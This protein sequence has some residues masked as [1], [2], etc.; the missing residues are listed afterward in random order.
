MPEKI[1]V[2]RLQ[3]FAGGVGVLSVPSVS[4]TFEI[5]ASWLAF[6]NPSTM[7]WSAIET[8]CQSYADLPPSLSSLPEHLMPT[9]LASSGTR[10]AQWLGALIVLFQRMVGDPLPSGQVVRI[11]DAGIEL[12]L[13][14]SRKQVFREALQLAAQYLFSWQPNRT[15][16]QTKIQ[17]LHQQ[18]LDFVQRFKPHGSVPAITRFVYA[19]QLLGLPYS[20]EEG[21]LTVGWG[22]YRQRLWGSLSDQD[23]PVG[24]NLAHNKLQTQRYLMRSGLPVPLSSPVKD[25]AQADQ[26][27]ETL[28][29]P[30]VLKP[31]NCEQGT[32]VVVGLNTPEQLH[33][34]LQSGIKA[35]YSMM[36]ERFVAGEDYRFLVVKG[37]VLRVAQR[38]PATVVGDGLHSIAQLIDQMN[39]DPR[40]GMGKDAFMVKVSVNEHLLSCLAAQNLTLDTVLA[41]GKSIRLGTV[42]NISQGGQA[43]DCS[44]KVHP[45]NVLLAVRCARV[46]GLSVAGIDFISQDIR[47]PWYEN[48][49]KIIEVNAQPGLRPHWLTDLNRDVNAEIL[50]LLCERGPRIPTAAITGTNGKTTVTR[51]L[52]HIWRKVGRCVGSCTT[53]GVWINDYNINPGHYPG[54]SGARMVL[55][56]PVVE[57]AIIELTRKTLMTQGHPCDRYDIGV[58]LN[59]QDDHVGSDGI[60]SIASMARLKSSVLERSQCLVINSEDFFCVEQAQ[61]VLSERGIKDKA[62]EALIYVA[63]NP[64]NQIFDQHIKM[65]GRGVSVAENA[66]G[67]NCIGFW[68]GS[69]SFI[70]CRLA[71]IP[72]TF[73]EFL[74]CNI[75]NALFSAA[76]A[77]GQGVA[78]ESIFEGLLTFKSSWD[79]NPG[80]FNFI[81]GFPFELWLDY[82]HNTDGVK[83]LCHF[84]SVQAFKGNN[85]KK[86]V[87]IT[88]IGNRHRKHIEESAELLV[89]VFDE[90][91]VGSQENVAYNSEYSSEDPA[92]EMVVFFRDKLIEKGVSEDKIVIE[93]D[94]VKAC[95]IG[96]ESTKPNEC[97]VLMTEPQYY[98]R[99]LLLSGLLK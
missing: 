49:A 8:L 9:E 76:V 18:L 61:R 27:S 56:D 5:P 86:R 99:A 12:V 19:A 36:L 87:V 6:E 67:Q 66:Q 20:L 90:F 74:N 26:L 24:L 21:C 14:W 51:M 31:V 71:D 96:L 97:L 37:Q 63:Q 7:Q 2:S 38:L 64:D 35:G 52:H 93:P 59:V 25:T 89:Q 45:D 98:Q 33:Q 72:A 46:L 41:V 70:G 69:E 44:D 47:R 62:S 79:M 53:E 65:G 80:R 34:A 40:R 84:L 16:D 48:E 68:Q 77:W 15:Q 32:G 17:H 4:V 78:K 95:Q 42:A 29:W 39:L 82:A 28:G 75:Q 88:Q 85:N 11:Q 57:V 13:P 91:V 50:Q 22:V 43:K 54:Y 1:S 60:D 92:K 81:P 94:T 58:L 83:A 23:S 30:L 10:V 55:S 73:N 3:F